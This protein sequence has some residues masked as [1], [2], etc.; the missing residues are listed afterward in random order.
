MSSNIRRFVVAHRTRDY[1]MVLQTRECKNAIACLPSMKVGPNYQPAN[2]AKDLP[3]ALAHACKEAILFYRSTEKPIV[4]LNPTD[5]RHTLV[6][7]EN[8][9]ITFQPYQG[10][11]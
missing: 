7:I 8:A 11:I 4:L 10:A 3:L 2:I 6:T 5:G 1:I 9:N